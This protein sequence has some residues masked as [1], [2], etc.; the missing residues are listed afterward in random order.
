MRKR[1]MLFVML[2]VAAVGLPGIALAEDPIELTEYNFCDYFNQV[3]S[4]ELLDDLGEEWAYLIERLQPN[5]ADINGS[6]YID[7]TDS[8]NMIINVEGN[9]ILDAA[10]EFGLLQAILEDGTFNNGV[11][12]YDQVWAAWEQNVTQFRA[13]IGPAIAILDAIIP[14]IAPI[15]EAYV[16]LGDGD[17]TIFSAPTPENPDVP[18]VVQGTGSF[19]FVACLMAVLNAFVQDYLGFGFTD[20]TLDKENYSLLT[21]LLPGSDADGDGSSNYCEYYYFTP[22]L[23]PEEPVEGEVEGSV[24]GSVEGEGEGSAEGT[25]EGEAEGA[26]L[27]IEGEGEGEGAEEGEAHVPA[28]PSTVYV[29]AAL[30]ATFI[31]EYCP[32]GE[33]CEITLSGTEVVP[34]VDTVATGTMTAQPLLFNFTSDVTLRITVEHTV[35]D[36]A[37]VGIYQGAVGEGGTLIVNLGDPT[38]PVVHQLTPEEVELVMQDLPLYVGVSSVLYPGGEIRGQIECGGTP[39]GEGAEGEG[40]GEGAEG[41]GEEGEGAEGEGEGEEGEG[42]EGEGEGEGEVC[43]PDGLYGQAPDN[44]ILS[45]SDDAASNVMFDNFSGVTNDIGGVVWWGINSEGDRVT[46]CTREPDTYQVSFYEDD[47]GLPGTQAASF[48]LTPVRSEV[49]LLTE[50]AS[51]GL[52]LYRFEA[53]LPSVVSLAS[54]WV[55]IKGVN[56][57]T[58]CYFLWMGSS[59]G[60]GSSVFGEPGNYTVVGPDLAFCLTTTGPIEGAAEGEGEGAEGEGEEGEGAEGEGEGAEGEGAEGEGEGAEGEGE[61]GEVP[62]ECHAADQNCDNLVNLSEL[63]RVIQFFNSGGYH[64]QAG[65]ED[66][67]APGPGDTG[68][69]PHT[70]DYNSQDWLINLSELLRLIQFFNSGG[71]HPC[72][73]GEDGF[74]PGPAK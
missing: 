22:A 32:M 3:A 54:G 45:F 39:E 18:V 11:L 59:D 71:Y 42:A 27:A 51:A 52:M 1:N 36:P 10:N 29:T 62:S 14:G 9:G 2:A 58:G 19:G 66:G 13:D 64:C 15:L 69:A 8:D 16:T 38:S 30:D 50:G 57:A 34:P 23:C 46:A 65:T 28:D 4:N 37:E 5:N 21:D 7:T 40:E 6:F 35:V 48:T 12:N 53:G 31:P 43:G 74:C 73:G 17:Y 26:K 70:S 20:P 49:A 47:S 67:Y 61:E 68:C 24:E 63:L 33:P 60:N 25:V 41:E 56:V 55:S 44:S 72:A